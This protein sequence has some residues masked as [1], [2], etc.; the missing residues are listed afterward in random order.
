MQE[1]RF[2]HKKDNIKHLGA[3]AEAKIEEQK[4]TITRQKY[5]YWGNKKGFEVYEFFKSDILGT[6]RGIHYDGASIFA[7][8][9]LSLLAAL[10][11]IVYVWALPLLYLITSKHHKMAIRFKNGSNIYLIDKSKINMEAF[12]LALLKESNL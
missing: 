5:G 9:V 7:V 8:L 1:F 2:V 4:V 11:G 6:K 10:S 12:Q 3:V